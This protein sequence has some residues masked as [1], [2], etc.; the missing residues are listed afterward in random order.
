MET[1][2]Q[3]NELAQALNNAMKQANYVQ[4]TDGGYQGKYISESALVDEVRPALVDNGLMIIPTTVKS[5]NYDSYNNAK[6]SMMHRID[7]VMGYKL[8]HVS[9]QWL[10]MEIAG[11]DADSGSKAT[12][13]ALTYAHKALLR[14]LFAIRSGDDK[15]PQE[16]L[17]EFNTLG[18]KFYN[19]DWDK[20]RPK[21]C[22]HLSNG[23]YTSSTALDDEML[24]KGIRILSGRIEKSGTHK[25]EESK[26]AQKEMF[27]EEPNGAYAE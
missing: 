20:F 2:E 11:S 3:I 1:S 21:W 23:E 19:G 27:D 18:R 14:Q 25:N 6:G 16:L 17:Q 24:Q 5:M 13:K 12:T 26:G 8:I 10:Y 15:K 9:G 22:S 7:I 4:K